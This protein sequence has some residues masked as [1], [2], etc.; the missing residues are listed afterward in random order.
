[1]NPTLMAILTPTVVAAIV[2]AAALLGREFVTGRGERAKLAAERRR[3]DDDFAIRGQELLLKQ[4]ESL[5]RENANG[6]GREA[7]SRQRCRELERQ[8]STLEQRCRDLEAEVAALCLRLDRHEQLL[9]AAGAA[10]VLAGEP[11]P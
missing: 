1:M 4:I 6:K 3:V 9:P 7:E 5:W 11:T 10:A 8:C 2:S